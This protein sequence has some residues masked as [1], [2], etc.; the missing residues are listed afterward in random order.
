MKNLYLS[1]MRVLVTFEFA[2]MWTYDHIPSVF[3]QDFIS[4][5]GPKTAPTSAVLIEFFTVLYLGIA[6]HNVQNLKNS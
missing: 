3:V 1:I 2:F 5:I 6:P 4:D